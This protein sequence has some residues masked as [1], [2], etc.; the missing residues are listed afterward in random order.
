MNTLLF[1]DWI[2]A[3]IAGLTRRF[4]PSTAALYYGSDI[5]CTSDVDELWSEV[6][7]GSVR[8]L[9]EALIR[10]LQTPRGMLFRDPAFGTDIRGMLHVGQTEQQIQA[11]ARLVE[12]ECRKDDRVEAVTARVALST[13]GVL[14]IGVTVKPQGRDQTFELVFHV[15]D[16]GELT[17]LVSDGS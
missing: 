6:D 5:S 17:T 12:A 2:D 15:D 10:R 16:T 1:P 7:A 9:G 13:S 14:G 11:L 3:K 4:A 8:A